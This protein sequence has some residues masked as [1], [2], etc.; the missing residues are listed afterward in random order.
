MILCLTLAVSQ[1]LCSRSKQET[2]EAEAAALAAEAVAHE[3]VAQDTP[4]HNL[5]Q[6]PPPTPTSHLQTAPLPSENASKASFPTAWK[7]NTTF[8]NN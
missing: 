7:L 8:K 2:L 5:P 4:Q 6:P 1:V 3:T